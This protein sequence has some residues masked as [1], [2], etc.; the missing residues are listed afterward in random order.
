MNR[1]WQQHESLGQMEAVCITKML[2]TMHQTTEY[3]ISEHYC[4]RKFGVNLI[5]T[6]HLVVV[7]ALISFIY[8]SVWIAC[9]PADE[10]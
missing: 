3:Y 4:F 7:E 6:L 2:V 1:Y 8:S 5:L 10:S 9:M